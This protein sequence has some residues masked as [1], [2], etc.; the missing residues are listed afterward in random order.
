MNSGISSVSN[1]LQPL[2]LLE[3]TLI[4]CYILNKA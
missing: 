3:I 1:P 2:V 4:T